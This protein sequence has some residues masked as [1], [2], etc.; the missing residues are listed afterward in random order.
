[1]ALD[2]SQMFGAG[3]GIPELLPQQHPHE[4]GNAWDSPSLPPKLVK[5]RRLRLKRERTA[6]MVMYKNRKHGHAARKRR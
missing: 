2:F 5:A 4:H 6:R 3:M 1:M